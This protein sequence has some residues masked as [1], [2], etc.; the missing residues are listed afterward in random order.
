MLLSYGTHMKPA[1]RSKFKKKSSF[2]WNPNAHQGGRRSYEAKVTGWVIESH[3]IFDTHFNFVWYYRKEMFFYTS[4][5]SLCLLGCLVAKKVKY[6][7]IRFLLFN[8]FSYSDFFI[9]KMSRI[10]LM[11]IKKIYYFINSI[12]LICQQYALFKSNPKI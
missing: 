10:S 1:N 5:F 3:Q 4:P 2:N 11:F 7:N 8:H 6:K 12:S 9:Q